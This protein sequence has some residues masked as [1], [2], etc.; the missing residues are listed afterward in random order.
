MISL[1]SSIMVTGL[2]TINNIP[3][4]GQDILV[5][6][7][8]KNKIIAHCSTS[9]SGGF[10]CSVPKRYEG[11]KVY[12]LFKI[13][14]SEVVT[15]D[16]KEVTISAE[17][18]KVN[19][20]TQI[21]FYD[22]TMK[23]NTAPAGFKNMNFFIDPEEIEGVPKSLNPFF[24]SSTKESYSSYYFRSDPVE[25]TITIKVRKGIYNIYG[26]MI[27]VDNALGEKF[28]DYIADK[29]VNVEGNKPLPKDNANR[30]K[31]DVAESSV[32]LVDVITIK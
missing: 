15:V 26:N 13:R 6:S 8:E 32:I 27:V 22:L 3:A 20:D 1:I 24:Y 19:C 7:Q 5:V 9:S 25:K 17:P 29:M 21:G 31:I 14:T 11:K 12:F 30:F 4:P 10:N 2:L 16:V 18:L 23:I 28:P